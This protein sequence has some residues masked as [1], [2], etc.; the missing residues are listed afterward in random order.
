MSFVRLLN[1]H[2]IDDVDAFC[3]FTLESDA[4]H[5]WM[6]EYNAKKMEYPVNILPRLVLNEPV[7]VNANQFN[8]WT[9]YMV[10]MQD[11]EL[12]R[13]HLR[14]NIPDYPM[15]IDEWIAYVCRELE[16]RDTLFTIVVRDHHFVVLY[17]AQDNRIDVFDSCRKWTLKDNYAF[18]DQY[19]APIYRA[20]VYAWNLSHIPR[21]ETYGGK[22][23]NFSCAL[24]SYIQRAKLVN[25]S[26]ETAL[27]Y[28]MDAET[29][30]DYKTYIKNQPE[31]Y[32]YVVYYLGTR[33]T[34]R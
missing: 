5:C 25:T 20:L 17:I 4:F 16:K 33:T 31:F 19:I 30:V 11:A 27:K 22:F 32:A 3:E 21:V 14:V 23:S 15:R 13:E 7:V 10:R 26:G 8:E 2:G 28:S 18:L 34:E 6:L 12:Y 1:E 24:M 9:S 29:I